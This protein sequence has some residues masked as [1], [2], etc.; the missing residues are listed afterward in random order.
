MD[1]FEGLKYRALPNQ[2]S[3]RYNDRRF[4]LNLV[5]SND[6]LCFVAL[7]GAT[8]SDPKSVISSA[9]MSLCSRC[10]IGQTWYFDDKFSIELRIADNH[11]QLSNVLRRQF[12]FPQPLEMASQ[13]ERA[14]SG[15]GSPRT[16]NNPQS[17]D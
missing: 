6:S 11:R 10:I 16:D 2:G 12:Y 8:W 14:F 15:D 17:I 5:A 3:S 9:M 1:E 7:R 13:T 4:A